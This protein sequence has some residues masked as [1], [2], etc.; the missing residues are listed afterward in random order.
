LAPTALATIGV[1][2]LTVGLRID[3]LSGNGAGADREYHSTPAV[4]T[5]AAV[6]AAATLARTTL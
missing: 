5:A 6:M 1:G 3:T 4:A 2:R